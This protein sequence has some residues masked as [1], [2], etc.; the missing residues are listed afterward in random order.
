MPGSRNAAR[1]PNVA[2][3]RS[4][5]SDPAFTSGATF[6]M[7]TVVRAGALVA[8]FESVAVSVTGYVPNALY[9]CVGVAPLPVAPSPKSQATDSGR[10]PSGYDGALALTWR[11]ASPVRAPPGRPRGGRLGG[12]SW[13][14]P[15]PESAKVCP[16]TGTNAH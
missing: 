6:A 3:G 7:V 14:D 16:L 9:V 10:V 13:Q 11:V 12:M 8:P 4:D 2:P 1:K 5:A 15:L